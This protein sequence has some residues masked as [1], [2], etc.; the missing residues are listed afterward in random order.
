MAGTFYWA[1]IFAPHILNMISSKLIAFDAII[2]LAPVLLFSFASGI[3]LCL[4]TYIIL[5]KF[6][7][8]TIMTASASAMVLG[9]LTAIVIT[10]DPSDIY[11]VGIAAASGL[12]GGLLFFFRENKNM[13]A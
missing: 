11:S 2:M 10:R 5:K 12:A 9:A 7:R 6:K 4:P 1:I 13:K 3:F 8:F